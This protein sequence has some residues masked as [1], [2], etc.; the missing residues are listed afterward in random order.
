[1]NSSILLFLLFIVLGIF[2]LVRISARRSRLPRGWRARRFF[3]TQEGYSDQEMA[4]AEMKADAQYAAPVGPIARLTP[5]PEKEP[6]AVLPTNCPACGGPLHPNEVKWQDEIT[7]KC[8]YCG[9][10]VRGEKRS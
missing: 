6:K 7:A 9:R 5:N 8:P 4:A 2:L 1:M 3:R 10:T